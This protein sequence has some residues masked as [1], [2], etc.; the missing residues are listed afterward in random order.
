M[1]NNI[2]S[3]LSLCLFFTSYKTNGQNN[4]PNKIDKYMQA[5]VEFY[6]FSG[7]IL[8]S[9]NDSILFEKGYGLANRE[10]NISNTINTKFNIASNT[11]QFTAACILQLEEQGKLNLNDKLSKYFSGFEYGDT[12]TLHM[13][14]THSSGIQDYFGYK[15]FSEIKPVSITKDSLLNLIKT[16]LYD[17][18]PG[19]DL[20]YSNSNYFLLGLIVEKV[21]GQT[22]EDYLNEHILRIVGMNNTGVNKFDTILANR[23]S[24]YVSSSKG[25]VNAFNENYRPNLMFAVGSMYSTVDDL[26]KWNKALY[27]NTILNEESKRKMFFPYGFSIVEAKKNADP[28]T[29][30]PEKIDPF[31]FHLG[32]GVWADTFLTHKRTL[33]RGGTS[34][35]FSTINRYINDNICIVILQNNEENPDRITEALSGILFGVDYTIP[36]KFVPCK[37][38]PEIFKK[39]TGKWVGNVYDEKWTIDIFTKDNKLYRR[40]EGYPDIELIPESE[41]KFFYGDGEDKEFE[42]VINEKGKANTGWFTING[43]KFRRDRIK[44]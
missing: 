21:S 1:K 23:A 40:I 22:L 24:G 34:G 25:I 9:R 13:L 7:T 16:K 28:A 14:L 4:L 11:K 37:I 5:K 6:N 43:V 33:S 39:Y 3:L 35:F 18:L 31:W 10:W 2:F 30:M 19:V 17:F 27:S 44:D 12:V 26:Y 38:N 32:Y 29:T 8:I 41:S 36:H 42:F 15:E 20:H